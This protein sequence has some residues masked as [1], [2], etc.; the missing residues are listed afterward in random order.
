MIGYKDALQAMGRQLARARAE[1]SL[2]QER[3]AA[4]A[5]M[6]REHLRAI[7]AGSVN[8][9]VGKLLSLCEVLKLDA[10]TLVRELQK[11]S[12][13][14]PTGRPAKKASRR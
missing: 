11:A 13:R 4:H 6:S 3:A 14:K 1:R 5:E 8:P 10:G 2:S 9:S 12:R 7:E